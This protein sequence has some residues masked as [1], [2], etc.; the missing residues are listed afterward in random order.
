MHK[1]CITLAFLGAFFASMLVSNTTFA[2]ASTIID[3][4]V[5]TVN[6][7][8]QMSGLKKLV[9]SQVQT[10]NSSNTPLQSKTK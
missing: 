2:H 7:V 1:T 9:D 5:Y 6:S 10:N 8:S 3:N 4:T